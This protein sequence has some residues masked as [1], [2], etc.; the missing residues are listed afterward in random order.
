[1]NLR[2]IDLNLLVVL[3]ALLD[4]AHVSRAAHRLNLSQPAVSSALQRCRALFGD[5]LLERGRGGMTRTPLA[6]TLR[7]PLR[8][9]LAEVE[10]LL[11]PGELPLDQI[12]RVV[13][14]TTAD[15][16]AALLV[17]PLVEALARTAPGITVVFRP[18]LGQDA[19]TRELLNGETD[20]AIA[21]FDRAIEN[22][23]IRTLFDV[24][25]V[26]AMRKNHPAA[27]AFD[28]DAWL[29]CPHVVVSGHG[30]MRTPLD[31]HLAVMGHRRRV[32]LVVPSFQL[33]PPVLAATDFI[34]MLPRQSLAAHA[35]LDLV[36]FRPPVAVDGFTLN[37][38]WH[39]RQNPDRA[40]QHVCG[41]VRETFHS[42]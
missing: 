25:Y 41:I 4:E 30:D 24:E 22:F 42:D 35:H 6:E 5:H 31:S 38:A 19:V 14:I 34:A 36:V 12:E 23:E 28:L 16:P 37:M 11:D 13:R 20:L 40:V 2:G 33:V 10:T 27:A 1:M 17:S 3:D 21:V 26:V 7:T 8:S 18:W 32:G 39:A 29:A 15:D 9:I